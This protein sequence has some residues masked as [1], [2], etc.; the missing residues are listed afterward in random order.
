[1]TRSPDVTQR[2]LFLLDEVSRKRSL[3]EKEQQGAGP[4]SPG[5]SRQVQP[6]LTIT[7]QISVSQQCTEIMSRYGFW[8]FSIS[9]GN[10]QEFRSFKSGMSDRI[11]SWLTKTNNTGSS[12]NP[13]VRPL[14]INLRLA[15]YPP[16]GPPDISVFR[17]GGQYVLSAAKFPPHFNTVSKIFKKLHKC[18]S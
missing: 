13:T 12:H 1:M 14:L 4:P 10:S 7:P 16:E 3:F 9:V 8:L 5:V 18:S 6:F 2:T 11:S 15:G 17:A